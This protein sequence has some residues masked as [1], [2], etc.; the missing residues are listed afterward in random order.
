ME[1]RMKAK[2]LSLALAA[3][4]LTTGAFALSSLGSGDAVAA[5]APARVYTVESS[6]APDPARHVLDLVRHFRNDD[7]RSLIQA[8]MPPEAWEE[9]RLKYEVERQQPTSE[10]DRARFAADW[11]RATSPDAVDRIMAEV[12]PKLAEARAQLPGALLMGFAA[13]QMAVESP[14]SGLTELQRRNLKALAPGVQQWATSV[15]FLSADRLRHAVT[16]VTDSLRDTGLDDL[17]AIKALPMEVL[18]DRFA[19]VLGAAKAAVREYGVDLDGVADS[20]QVEVLEMEDDVARIRTTITLLGGQVS[21]DHSL[22]LVD[23][24]WYPGELGTHFRSHRFRF[25]S[26]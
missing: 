15:D 9:A 16:L 10:S 3:A 18:V 20:L 13:L 19:P 5:T 12:E 23:G 7:V 17:E 1:H 8:T 24:R 22:I 6:Q 11:E 4:G 14:D 21:G 26:R 25:S 2:I